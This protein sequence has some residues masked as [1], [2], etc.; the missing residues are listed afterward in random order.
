M[1]AQHLETGFGPLEL[2]SLMGDERARADRHLDACDACA[3]AFRGSADALAALALSLPPAPPPSGHR[4]RVMRAV[5]DTSR[6]EQFTAQTAQVL[7]LAADTARALLARI[8]DAASWVASLLPGVSLYHLDGGPAVANAVVGFVRIQPGCFFP[9]HTHKGDEV[10]LV[11]QGSFALADGTVF[12]RGDLVRAPTDSSH[13]LTALPGPDFIYL[14]ASQNG[15]LLFG[16]H[17]KPGD[18]RA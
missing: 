2:E 12:K 17:I 13:E 10:M 1:S 4:D 6:F 3:A 11:L 16:E 5:S 7:D 14:S 8:D 18:P 15:F 9:D